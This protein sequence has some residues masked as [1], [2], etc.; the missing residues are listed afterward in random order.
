M[1]EFLQKISGSQLVGLTFWV[2]IG[3]VWITWIIAENWRR[4]R[5]TEL[6]TML[7]QE[8][9]QRG[10]SADEIVKVL[11]ASKGGSKPTDAESPP[12]E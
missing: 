8:M 11:K 9:L 10:M 1:S 12:T 5:K 7:K 6:E 2:V 3:L 4:A